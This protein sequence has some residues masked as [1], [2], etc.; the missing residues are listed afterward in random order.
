MPALVLLKH[1]VT[2]QEK[3]FALNDEA[4]CQRLEELRAVKI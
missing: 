2:A 1:V 4:V 3:Q